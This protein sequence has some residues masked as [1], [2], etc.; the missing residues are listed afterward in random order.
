MAK[1]KPP[2]QYVQIP[3]E[4]LEQTLE[5]KV[6]RHVQME[7]FKGPIPSP[8]KMEKY[9]HLYPGAVKFFFETLKNQT[10]HRIELEKKVIG[11]NIKSE[12]R[13]SWFGFIIAMTAIIGGI[14]LAL[15]DKKTGGI[16][17][18]IS[19]LSSLVIVFIVGKVHSK[20][21]INQKK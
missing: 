6:E 20:K 1:R 10:N 3:E 15:L 13:G 12:R 4:Q 8:E 2:R 5:E 9:E 19:G 16:A 11:S 18:I 17:A 14:V 21:E 7:M